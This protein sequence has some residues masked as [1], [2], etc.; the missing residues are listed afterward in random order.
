MTKVIFLDDSTINVVARDGEQF[1]FKTLPV[2]KDNQ[3]RIKNLMTFHFDENF[4]DDKTNMIYWVQMKMFG[5]IFFWHCDSDRKEERE[6]IGSKIRQIRET[7]GME[8]KVLAKL[9]NIDA[10]NF[11]RIEQGNYSVGLDILSRIAKALGVK[12]DLVSI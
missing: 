5:E 3:Q 1:T 10:A 9:A 8:A 2:P 12:V 7:R 6:R 4:S 11:S